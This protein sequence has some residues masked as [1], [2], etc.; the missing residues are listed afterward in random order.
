MFRV[1][2]LATNIYISFPSSSSNLSNELLP[3]NSI[4][5]SFLTTCS[6]NY[7]NAATYYAMH[8]FFFLFRT[9]SIL[10]WRIVLSRQSNHKLHQLL[11]HHLLFCHTLFFVVLF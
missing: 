4:I 5:S 10:K 6:T 11:R 2:S 7:F 3:T 9:L 1:S 8:S